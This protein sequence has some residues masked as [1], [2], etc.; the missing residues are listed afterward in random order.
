MTLF[1]CTTLIT[2]KLGLVFPNILLDEW[3]SGLLGGWLYG[4]MFVHFDGLLAN[5]VYGNPVI[6]FKTKELDYCGTVLLQY[7]LDT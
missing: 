7:S 3:M 4:F 6:C 1:S 5:W 2:P